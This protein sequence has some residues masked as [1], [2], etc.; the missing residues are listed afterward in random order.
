[1]IIRVIIVNTGFKEHSTAIWKISYSTIHEGIQTSF[2]G[3]T[4][5]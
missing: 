1:M 3:Q 2:R 4:S 5:H